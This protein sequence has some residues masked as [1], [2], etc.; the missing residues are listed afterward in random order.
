MNPLY[1]YA[2][3]RRDL[4]VHQQAIQSGHAQLEYCRNFGVPEGEHPNFVWL[5][6]E[7]KRE[8]LNLASVL[9]S[10]GVKVGM[11][12]DPDY[13]GYDPSALACILTNEQRFLLSDLPLW[14]CSAE[15]PPKT[16]FLKSLFRVK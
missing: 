2:V 15:A 6:V 1:F 7:G 9:G 12:I 16:N 11:F 4:P 10:F 3:S 13:P 14:K 8:L 5:T